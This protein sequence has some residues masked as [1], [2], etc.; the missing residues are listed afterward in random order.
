MNKE[1]RRKINDG[2]ESLM[3]ARDILQ[4]VLNDEQFVFDNMPENLQGSIRGMESEDAVNC[5]EESIEKIEE[6]ISE[7]GG[8]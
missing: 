7:L 4:K 6:V 1:R 8:I 2:V 5:L 3:R